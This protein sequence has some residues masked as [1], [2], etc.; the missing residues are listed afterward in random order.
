MHPM[1]AAVFNAELRG[2]NPP[3]SR[4]EMSP[5][6]TEVTH[7]HVVGPVVTRWP[8]DVRIVERRRCTRFLFKAPT[9]IAM[10]KDPAGGR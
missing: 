8:A 10:R 9:T 6:R 1:N 4:K 5:S 7:D 2:D 3:A